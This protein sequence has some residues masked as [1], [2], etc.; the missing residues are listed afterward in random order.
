MAW[1]SW[2]HRVTENAWAN[3]HE[4]KTS[5]AWAVIWWFIPVANLWMPAV[6]LYRVYRASLGARNRGGTWLIGVWWT[7][8]LLAPVVAGGFVTF[9]LGFRIGRALRF[10]SLSPDRVAVLDLTKSL[11]AF[12]PWALTVAL[13]QIPAALLAIAIVTRIDQAQE[14]RGPLVPPRPDFPY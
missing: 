3:R 5:P 13:M 11:H 1:L 7:T 8:N 2:Q 12:A 10:A 6:A 14:S 9:V 4:I